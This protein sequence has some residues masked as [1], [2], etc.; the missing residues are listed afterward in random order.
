MRVLIWV[1]VVL[2]ALW[3]GYWFVGQRAVDR[4]TEGFFQSA[5]RQGLV[6]EKAGHRVAGFPNRFDLTIDAPHLADPVK[7]LDWSAPFLQILSLSYKPWHVILAFPPEQV[8]TTP[9]DRLTIASDGKLQASLVVTPGPDLALDRTTLVGTGLAVTAED[10]ARLT[11]AEL[12]FATRLDPTR[13]NSHEIGLEVTGIAPDPGLT[14]ALPDLPPAIDRI[15]LDAFAGFSA[16]IDRHARQTRPDLTAFTLR[17]AVL[18]WGALTVF[19]KG[20]LVFDR[21]V[22]DGRLDV[23]IEGWRHLVGLMTATG[24]IKPEVAPTVERM[25]ETL[26]AQS[27][28]GTALNLPLAFNAGQM[29]LGPLPLGPAPWLVQRQ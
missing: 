9:R 21:G 17:E 10:G 1:S 19:V 6:A 8:L 20:D 28:D 14:A 25:L 23:R 15:R 11:A 13:T 29:R 26:A 4:A 5:S 3:S 24:L 12:R 16:P 22:P 7:G 27:G 18:A 2:V